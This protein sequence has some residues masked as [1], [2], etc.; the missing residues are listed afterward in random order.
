MYLRVG[1]KSSWNYMVY[2]RGI[3]ANLEKI[4]ALQVMRLPTKIKKMQ[5]LTGRI[6]IL[7]R[8]V[9]KS[10]DMSK[11]FFD[12]LH[13]GKEFKWN[14]VLYDAELRYS[15]MEKLAY[16]LIM[17]TRK[18]MPYFLATPSRNFD[19][20]PSN[21]GPPKTRYFWKNCEIGG[22]AWPVQ[23]PFQTPNF[24][25]SSRLADFVV[26]FSLKTEPSTKDEE[27][28]TLFVDGSSTETHARAGVILDEPYSRART[29]IIEIPRTQNSLTDALAL[30]AISKGI[31]ELENI[32]FRRIGNAT[33]NQPKLMLTTIDLDPNWMD[34]IV[35]FFKDGRVLPDSMEARK[36]KD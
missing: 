14:E 11:P 28:W 32:L 3:E 15:P 13:G 34:E 36:N 1:R 30:I 2:Q 12:A 5:S 8:F 35:G 16:A 21:V 20:L 7:S 10:T 31:E 22:R 23:L 4:I 18:L 19:K 17:S 24:Y 27:S 25:Q 6:A 33:I 9:S 29:Q 26:E